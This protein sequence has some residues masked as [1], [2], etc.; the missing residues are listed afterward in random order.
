MLLNPGLALLTGVCGGIL[1]A[2]GISFL[3]PWLKRHGLTDTCGI[4]CLHLIP[5]VLGVCA[6]ALHEYKSVSQLLHMNIRMNACGNAAND[7][8][9]IIVRLWM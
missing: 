7:M 1:S 8:V 4:S 3:K 2:Y 6:R 9:C 5:G